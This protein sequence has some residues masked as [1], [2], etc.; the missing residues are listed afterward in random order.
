MVHPVDQTSISSNGSSLLVSSRKITVT[1]KTYSYD[2]KAFKVPDN[3]RAN[4][5]Q[6]MSVEWGW[7]A[8]LNLCGN[9]KAAGCKED[10]PICQFDGTT[11]YFHLERLRR[12]L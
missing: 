7:M 4:F 5:I 1:Q 9:A 11:N 12:G 8:V 3:H 10:T 2:L 6:G